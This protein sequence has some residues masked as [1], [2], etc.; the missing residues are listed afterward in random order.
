MNKHQVSVSTILFYL[1]GL[2]GWHG[3]WP[4]LAQW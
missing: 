2:I 4:S 1:W 3:G